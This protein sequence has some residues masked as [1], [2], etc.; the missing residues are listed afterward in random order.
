M[1]H[2]SSLTLWQPQ[3]G[4]D[5]RQR[6]PHFN[7]GW[8][9]HSC[10]LL[11]AG[12]SFAS[13]G[14]ASCFSAQGSFYRLLTSLFVQVAQNHQTGIAGAKIADAPL[15][16]MYQNLW[17]KLWLWL[18]RF[19]K[20]STSLKHRCCSQNLVCSLR[21]SDKYVSS[22]VCKASRDQRED[23]VFGIVLSGRDVPIG[24]IEGPLCCRE[25]WSCVRWFKTS[26]NQLKS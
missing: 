15:C 24:G 7:A 5:L 3:R 6:W 18:P 14:Y 17:L 4:V 2:S 21:Q 16:Q 25:D 9:R 1:L 19:H 26:H 23:V 10:R 12:A 22:S 11:S 13:G 8:W 20:R